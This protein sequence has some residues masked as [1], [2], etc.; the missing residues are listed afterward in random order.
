M[1]KPCY[2]GKTKLTP[3]FMKYAKEDDVKRILGISK[4]YSFEPFIVEIDGKTY[5]VIDKEKK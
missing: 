5:K 4:K 2:F 1:G 3:D